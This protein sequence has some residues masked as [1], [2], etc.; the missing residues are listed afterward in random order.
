MALTIGFYAMALIL[1]LGVLSIPIILAYITG[2]I[3]F[4]VVFVCLITGITILWAAA[5]R[6]DKFVPPGPLL[7]PSANP[8]LFEIIAEMAKKTA[9]RM[10]DHV[11]LVYDFNA[12]V[13]ER[14]GVGGFGGDRIMGLGLPL[15]KEVNIAQFKAI[16]AHEFGHYYNGDTSIGSRIYRIHAAIE[17]TLTSL[18]NNRSIMQLPFKWYGKKILKVTSGVSRSQEF[19]A[20]KLSATLVG[21]DVVIDALET[22][23]MKGAA[24]GEYW[25]D[26][27]APMIESGLLPPFLEGFSRYLK[28][29]TI[30]KKM[31]EAIQDELKRTKT[32]EYD[33]HP[34]IKERLNAIAAMNC[35]GGKIDP[36][37]A[38]NLVK[39]PERLERA[40]LKSTI[41]YDYFKTLKPM[42]WDDD[43][44]PLYISNWENDLK[45]FTKLLQQVTPDKLP[46][47][48]KNPIDCMKMIDSRKIIP[49]IE[50]PYIIHRLQFILSAGLGLMLLQDDWNFHK[51]L[52]EEILFTKGD[53]KLNPFS[54]IPELTDGKLTQNQWIE[55]CNIHSIAHRSLFTQAV[56]VS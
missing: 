10:P 40:I 4:R 38:I 31:T 29:D 48:V 17:R 51:R 45:G 27:F 50:F 49:Q 34:T 54:V 16:I 3:Y 23:A 6:R 2:H 18:Q 13:A 14:G 55:F 33:S 35:D 9:Q 12:W 11:Y 37:P 52:G 46:E 28:M 19:V 44:A 26:E 22:S 32:D 20:D 36:T 43:V 56:K 53:A 47:I 1:G 8:K 5:P 30:Q 25:S 42:S 39:D 7:T 24:F 21:K 15:L 41:K